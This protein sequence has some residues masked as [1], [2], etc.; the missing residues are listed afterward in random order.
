M[1]LGILTWLILLPVAASFALLFFKRDRTTEIKV[2][3]FIVTL[4]I[5]LLSLELFVNF[6]AAKSGMQFEQIHAWIPQFGINYHVGVD[7][8]SLFLVLLTTLLGPI[9]VLCSWKQIEKR[10]KEFF[11]ALLLLEAGVIGVFVS[12]DLI[13]FYI[14]WEAM[15]IPMYLLIGIWG[16]ESRIY[17]AVKFF[18][19]T[20]VGSL[21]MFVAILYLYSRTGTFDVQGMQ[22]KLHL[23]FAVQCWL[24]LAFG[25]SFAIKVPLFPFHTWLPWAHTEAPTAGSVILAGVLLKMGVYGFLRFAIPFFPQAA[26]YFTPAIAVL[27]I[28]GIIYGALMSLAQDDLKKLIAYSSVSHLGYVMLGIFAFNV[29]G[30]EGGI[31][32]MLNHGVSTGALFLLVGFI[33][34]RRH[35]REI[36]EYGGIAKVI[37]VYAVIFMIVTLSSIGLPGT[38]GFIGEFLILLGAFEARNIY[39]ILAASGV[40]LGAAYMLWLYQRIF[41]GKITNP[42][43]EHLEDVNKREMA[44]LLPLLILIFVMG[45]MP[46]IFLSRT[47]KSVNDFLKNQAAYFQGINKP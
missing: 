11:I 34:E 15:L 30:M 18:I 27:A 2:F 32:Q 41:F 31:Y 26:Q 24:F 35:T 37:P 21:L 17:A 42:K 39:G 6:S 43:N 44:Y 38:N 28:I 45:L 7:G 3:A 20:M 1:N 12:L 46:N 29:R 10:I 36:S 8:I 33:Y 16:G 22:W 14:F 47:A 4:L 19:Y 23:P 40:V 9:C 25:L 5:F 13:M